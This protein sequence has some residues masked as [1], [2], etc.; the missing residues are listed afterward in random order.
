L[1]YAQVVPPAIGYAVLAGAAVGLWL[2][3]RRG[4]WREGLLI[5]WAAVPAAF[6]EIW[7]VKGYQYLLVAA[8]VAAV[9]AA[10]AL[11]FVPIQGW[12]TA[13][14]R[15]ASPA[16]RATVITAVVASL[17]VP[18][19]QLVNPQ[20]TTTF[21]A[22]SGGLPAGREMGK[23]MDTNLPLQSRVM[24][25]GPSTANIV[26]FY[27]RRPAVGLSISPNP[28]SRNPSYEP[29]DNPDR[30]LRQGTIHYVV[31]DAFTAER[32]P[33][34]AGRLM[35]YVDKYHGRVLHTETISI[36][37]DDGGEVDKPVMIVYEVRP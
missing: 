2:L 25:I 20:P 31:W 29:I 28:L 35:R 7:P 18:S 10:R 21:L 30:E 19:W 6:F 16:I 1:F 11:V 8:P 36:R 26:R 37:E 22:G 5:C 3:R 14:H 9:L 34:F 27:G 15:H 32:T 4:G 17:A 13:W 23:W 33:F 24:T 12:A